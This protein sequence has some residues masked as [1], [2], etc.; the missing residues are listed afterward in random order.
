MLQ[1]STLKL[2]RF[3]FSI[4]LMPVFWFA[5]S[6]QQHIDITKAILL[7][8]ILHLLVYPSS[9]GYN[10]YMDKDTGSIGGIENPPEPLKEL[11]VVSVIMDILAILLSLFV[12]PLTS[13]LLFVYI[14]FSRLYSYRGVRLKQYPISGYLTVILNQGSLVFAIIYLGVGEGASVLPYYPLIAAAFL[15]GGFYPITQ[16]YQHD[17]DKA[18]GVNSISLMLGKRGTFIFCAFIYILAFAFLIGYFQQLN[19]LYLFYV[20]QLFFIPVVIYFLIWAK[21]VWKDETKADFKH[22]MR[23]NWIASIGSN[24]GFISLLILEQRG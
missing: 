17:A 2:L 18:D 22:T 10:S 7:F 1:P 9:N 14:V 6:I 8:I 5:L 4:F 13:L 11:F 15:I 24:A 16:I 23:M 21:Q 12:S 20:L 3:P 19:K